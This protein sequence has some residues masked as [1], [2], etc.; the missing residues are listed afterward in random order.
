MEK[1]LVHL[2]DDDIAVRGTLA[3]L[4]QSG[5]YRVHEYASGTELLAAANRLA[6]GCIL[7]D[8]RMP[9]PDG[10]AVKK[11]LASK[12]VDLPVIMMTGGGDL[13]ML[14]LKAGVVELMLKPFGR[15]ELLAVI[16]QF[17]VPRARAAS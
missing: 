11:I 17:A 4:L 3:R 16:D 12:S 7:L 1:G 15:S 10:F 9:E 14:A 13:G 2:V 5:G 6:E 8:I